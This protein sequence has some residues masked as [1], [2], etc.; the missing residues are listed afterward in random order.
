V[1]NFGTG[2]SHVI[3][4]HVLMDRKGFAFAP[5]VMLYFAHQDEF[6]GAV[7]HLARLAAD[8]VAVPYPSLDEVVKKSGYTPDTSRGMTYA[9][10]EPLARD[11]VLGVYRHLIA[12]CRR[13]GVVP[14]WVYLPMPGIAE[15]PARSDVFVRLAAEA[16]F[17]V[18]DLSDW[19][20]GH[21]PA[22]VKA[23]AASYHPNAL[24]HR[25]IAERLAAELGRRPGLLP[26]G[27]GP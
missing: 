21:R 4:R 19:A 5:D 20:E 27:R 16:G 18:V 8:G 3:H 7:Q 10:I 22:D 11:I 25:L 13:R 15:A 23:T 6:R 26:T 2:R 12:E 24:G 1:L 17:T 14:V 9:L